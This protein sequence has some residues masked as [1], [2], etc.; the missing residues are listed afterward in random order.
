M[1][2]NMCTCV[3]DGDLRRLARLLRAGATPNAA[4]YDLRTPLHIAAA[5]GSLAA[6]QLLLDGGRCDLLATDR[7]GATAIDEARRC[8]LCPCTPWHASPGMHAVWP[9]SYALQQQLGQPLSVDQRRS[10]VVERAA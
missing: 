7:W 6:V 4:D 10:C 5:E 2:A 8:A 9:V 1:A 3:Y